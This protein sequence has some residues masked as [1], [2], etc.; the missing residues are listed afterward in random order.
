LKVAAAAEA[1]RAG[2][3]AII[4]TETVYGVAGSAKSAEAVAFLK[5]RPEAPD[6]LVP[7][8]KA[9]TWHAPSVAVVI[10]TLR[11]TNLLHRRIF[12]RM[13][14]GPVR[15]LVQKAQ[16]DVTTILTELGLPHGVIEHA[17]EFSVRIPDHPVAKEI[18]EEAGVTVV[19]ERTSAFGLGDGRTLPEDIEQLAAK[20]GITA[21]VD[22]GPT[23][24]GKPST[25]VRLNLDGGY[26]VLPGGLYDERYIR[27]KVERVVL[28]VCTG[29]TCRSP[30][31]AAI[32]QDYLARSKSPIPTRVMSAGVAAAAGE[33]MTPEAREALHE[34][35]IEAG[36][37]RA[38]EL[39]RDQVKDAE[40]I[41]GMT[42]AHVQAVLEMA[43]FAAG[44]I[45]PLDPEGADV[46]D[47]IGGSPQE[48][49]ATALRL[50]QLVERRLMELLA[51]SVKET[52]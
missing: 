1:I 15:F 11:I 18:L 38:H 43:P 39:T 20:A 12:S 28:F 22:D 35:K 23:R 29:N 52:P 41:Y 33:P 51:A 21:V 8:A 4:P 30:M 13:A 48:Y 24:L 32:A 16:G 27:K 26:D 46:P 50:K 5:N 9:S 7:A 17:G 45:F 36:P 10:K 31:A 2:K 37:W 44:K 3:L 47:P 49:R 14:P 40:V 42:K 19:A 6:H 25:A 34:L